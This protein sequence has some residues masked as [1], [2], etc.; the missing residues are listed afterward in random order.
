MS[1][2]VPEPEQVA[3]AAFS[4]E[5]L[6]YQRLEH[7]LFRFVQ[8]LKKWGLIEA[9]SLDVMFAHV[10]DLHKVTKMHIQILQ[11]QSDKGDSTQAKIEDLVRL[12]SDDNLYVLYNKYV[13][14]Y[15]E[16]E[17]TVERCKLQ[18]ERFWAFLNGQERATS[19]SMMHLLSQ[20]VLH[21]MVIADIV[22]KLLMCL[23]DNHGMKGKLKY[24]SEK[25][26]SLN[27]SVD[28]DQRVQANAEKMAS[29]E[30][31][32]PVDRLELSIA[33]EDEDSKR[34]STL[35]RAGVKYTYNKAVNEAQNEYLKCASSEYHIV[36]QM[37]GSGT[38]WYIT[39]EDVFDGPEKDGHKRKTFVFDDVI[40]LAKPRTKSSFALRRRYK[41]SESWVG[42]SEEMDAIN[43]IVLGS[44]Y[45]RHEVITFVNLHKKRKFVDT[46]RKLIDVARENDPKN[47]GTVS[48]FPFLTVDPNAYISGLPKYQTVQASLHHT[49][50][51]V[52]RNTLL[53][54]SK[55]DNPNPDPNAFVLYELTTHGIIKLNRWECPLVINR[56]GSRCHLHRSHCQYIVRP[57][58]AVPLTVEN[59]PA[60]LQLLVS[61]ASEK[62]QRRISESGTPQGRVLTAAEQ[63]DQLNREKKKG[64]VKSFLSKRLGFGG[65]GKGSVEEAATS[66]SPPPT[67]IGELYR[68]PLDELY[69]DGHLPKPLEHMI[70]RLYYDGPQAVGLFRK[71]A[72]ARVCRQVRERL[73]AGQDV[74]FVELPVLAVGAI[75]K[76]FLRL[77]PDS[78]MTLA[79]YDDMVACNAIHLQNQR[80]EKVHKVLARLPESSRY[81]LGALMPVF[82]QI[83]KEENSNNMTASNVGICIGQSMM[84]P[85]TT[86]DILKNDVPPFIEYMILNFKSL[87]GDESKHVIFDQLE[88]NPR[89]IDRMDSIAME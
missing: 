31:S 2:P 88:S 83:C 35:R 71:S 5:S 49:V 39:E 8:P 1:E 55:Q 64:L 7:L 14:S 54:M 74:D 45:H 22:R 37:R 86:E 80:L 23:P 62:P 73:D 17:K 3:R 33:K 69:V 12:F 10:P 68:R 46:I 41:L 25:W 87:F 24:S 18:H 30:L 53:R 20:P 32:F 78:V 28:L 72:N 51:D 57:A 61:H 56:V 40:L 42:E 34:K 44:P 50:V 82:V 36:L 84:W 29:I 79:L 48:V 70:S 60:A 63:L 75:L 38:R 58:K 59:L 15:P 65:V 13:E 47:T 6:Y 16:I 43:G 19:Y 76:E 77:L 89:L 66:S 52:I 26:T 21:V 11:P 67:P 81:L 9:S 85:R 27:E 4:Y